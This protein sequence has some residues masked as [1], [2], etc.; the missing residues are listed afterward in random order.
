M[1]TVDEK[2]LVFLVADAPS[3][4]KGHVET[5]VAPNQIRLEMVGLLETPECAFF[6]KAV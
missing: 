4:G 1:A 3:H 6:T 2:P 5:A